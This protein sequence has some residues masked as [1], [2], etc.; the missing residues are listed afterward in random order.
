MAPAPAIDGR[1]LHG[2]IPYS[3]ESRDLGGFTEVIEPGALTGADLSD[4]I[5]TREHDRSK[6]LGRHPST[7]TVEDRADGFAWSVELPQ[8][9]VGEDVRVAI[10]RGDLRS[11]SWRM[12]VGRDRWEGDKRIVEQIA[13][14]ADV[15]VTAS[16]AYGDAAPAE[17]RSAPEPD[18]APPAPDDPQEQENPMQTEDRTEAPAGGLAIEDRSAAP[19]S[20][21]ERIADG[22]RG[23]RKGESR[24]LTTAA[25]V[26]PGELSTVLFDRLRAA[27]VVLST[28]IK[29]LSITADS[30][31]YPTLTGDAAPAWTAEAATITPGDPT[32]ATLTATPRKLAH[33]VQFSNEVLDDSD[34]SIA[35]ILN[36]HL[37]STLALKLDAGLLE[38]SGTP[39]EIRGLKNIVGTQSVSAGVNGA[40]A[41]LDQ[42]A[43]AIALLESVNVPRERMRIV[44]HPRN[45][46]TLRK[47]KASTGGTYLWSADPSTSSPSGIFG[48]PVYTSPQL[49][50]AETQ[51][52]SGAVAN[53]AY[54]YDIESLVYVQRTPIE[55]ELDR[56][57]LF[58]S[59]QSEMRAKLRGDLIAPTPTG[60]VR[61]VGLLA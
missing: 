40:S 8:S 32:F 23:V 33:L 37:M 14:L 10:E 31:T 18:P 25:S 35:A 1:R 3:V 28:G 6:L 13:Q 48:V 41:T 19:P 34:P 44:V 5:A 29:T 47:L 22:L 7:L 9:P 59:D 49:G 57:R 45:V 4:L 51:G 43:D 20:V 12:V 39:P 60:I 16:P 54:V 36:A 24:A 21:E 46:A 52:T 53:S 61:V 15:T 26:S 42:F 2:L 56:S 50:T 55:V 30:V 27:S 58:N 11:T 17:Y 38:G